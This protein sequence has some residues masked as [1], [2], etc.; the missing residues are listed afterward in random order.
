MNEHQK[1]C[2]SLLISMIIE[3]FVWP[4]GYRRIMVLEDGAILCCNCVR[5]EARR[6]MSDIRDDYD[7]GWMP[8]ANS[9]EAVSPE[10]IRDNPDY[11]TH[12]EHCNEPVGELGC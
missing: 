4:G 5:R 1:R 2:R 7:T 8:A 12:C 9:Y 11:I 10:D 3:P 6:I